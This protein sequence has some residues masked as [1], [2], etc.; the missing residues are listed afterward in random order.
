MS[1]DKT[2]AG[3]F[4]ANPDA[5]VQNNLH[6]VDP[7]TPGT[8]LEDTATINT[9]G[10][11]QF[12]GIKYTNKDGDTVTIRFE[13]T[14]PPSN[15]RVPFTVLVAEGRDV[16]L[17]A[18]RLAITQHEVG[19]IITVGGSGVSYDVLHIGSGTITALIMDGADQALSRG[20]I[21]GFELETQDAL[22]AFS[23]ANPDAK[24]KKGKKAK[25]Q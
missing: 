19:P 7:N 13:K 16:L 23:A 18:L 4:R 5:I 22:A 24:V 3:Q 6:L 8:P 25:A 21:T 20:A 1:F 12:E 15:Q 2:T 17:E 11:V 10:A 14:I 9:T